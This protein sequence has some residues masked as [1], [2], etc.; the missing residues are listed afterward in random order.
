[1]E[2]KEEAKKAE[3]EEVWKRSMKNQRDAQNRVLSCA[4]WARIIKNPDVSTGPL[5]CPFAHSL[6]LL[7]R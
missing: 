3:K 5:A 7:T 4:L 2:K 6:A 1:M